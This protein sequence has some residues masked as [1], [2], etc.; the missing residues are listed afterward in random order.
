VKVSVIAPSQISL[1]AATA[2]DREFLVAL[3]GA[4][5]T[6]LARLPLDETQRDALVRMQFH[7][8]DVHYRQTTPDA[9]FDVIEVDGRPVGRLYV[10]RRVDDIRIVD[11]SL[12]PEHRNAG[13]GTTLIRAL[14]DEAAATGRGVSLHV[15]MGNP[16]AGLYSRLGFQLVADDGIYRRLEWS[17]P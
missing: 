15:A 3:Y 9:A 2:D 10:D 7:A 5:R 12:L 13:I 8:Q 17:A 1:R 14:Q 16:A 6:D 4:T 11:V